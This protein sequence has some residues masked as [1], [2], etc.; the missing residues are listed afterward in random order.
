MLIFQILK[1][2]MMYSQYSD[3][4]KSRLLLDFHNEEKTAWEME[5]HL[6]T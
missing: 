1:L 3:G 2:N 5:R 6:L 4:M